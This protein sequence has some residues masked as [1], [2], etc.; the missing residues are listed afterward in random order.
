MASTTALRLVDERGWRSGL[1]NLLRREAYTWWG[2]RFG[3]LQVLIWVVI[4]NGI[5][6]LVLYTEGEE[7]AEGAELASMAVEVFFPMAMIF[8]T[9]GLVIIAQGA[10]VGEKR[11]GT[12]A[13]ILS[14]PVSRSAFLLSKLIPIALGS[15]VTMLVLPGVI[16]YLQIS[17]ASGTAMSAIPF[18]AGMSVVAVHLAFYLS[19]TLMLGTVFNTRGPV[20]SV[21]IVL[22]FGGGLLMGFA[23]SWLARATHW[24]LSELAIALGQMQT[25]DSFVP[26]FATAAWSVVFVLVAIWRFRREEF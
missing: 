8:T 23:P 13:W 19:L 7:G 17:Y 9:L 22:L 5:L 20:I 24:P 11:S 18:L 21:P 2:T 14:G 10:V 25:P 1:V 15:L 12:V 6:A 26:I 16:A 4:L 3:L